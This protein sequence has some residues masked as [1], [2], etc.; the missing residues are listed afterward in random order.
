MP[1]D[2]AALILSLIA[3]GVS[4]AGI[5]F[6][7][8]RSAQATALAREALDESKEATSVAHWS[9]AQEAV[10]HL[11]GFDPNQQPVDER[12]VNL[13]VA[14]VALV[15]HLDGWEGF[16]RWLEAERVLG[17]TIARQ[18]LER[19]ESS[20]D[21]ETRLANLDPLLRWA[22]A[23]SQNL[24]RFRRVGYDAVA[25]RDLCVNAEKVNREVCDANGWDAPPSVGQ[26]SS[27]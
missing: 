26:A 19:S 24:R 25:V 1:L 15:D 2:I 6:Q 8:R 14:L 4:I 27:H 12:L 21:V 22:G 3:V 20:D 9:A 5:A 11:I 18:V 16:D 23:L 7:D 13:R 17:A 10:Q